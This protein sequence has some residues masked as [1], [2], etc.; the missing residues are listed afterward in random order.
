MLA[1]I[2]GAVDKPDGFRKIH[3]REIPRLGGV[4]V[5]IAF[6]VPIFLLM[7][8]Y[9]RSLISTVLKEHIISVTGLLVGASVAL[10]MGAIDD[11]VDLRARWKLLLQ[12]FAAC[13][14]ITAGY[15]IEILSLP[16]IGTI[17]L[18]WLTWPFTIFWFLGC[19]NAINFLDGMD[20]LAG[21]VSLIVCIT[22]VLVGLLMDNPMSMFLMACL[23]GAILG[24]L[25]HNFHPA[26]IFLG[27]SGSNVLGF[28]IAA[29]AIGSSRK[30]ETA[31]ALLIP[32]IALGL[33]IIDTGLA[34]LRRWSRRLPMSAP[35]RQHIHHLLLSMGLS[36]TK[37]VLI[38]YLASVLLC[39]VAILSIADERELLILLFICVAVV[40]F[41]CVRL[42][43]AVPISELRN[44]FTM[45][46]RQREQANLARI[47]T[48]KALHRM[49]YT[50]E[51]GE[52]WELCAL[53]LTCLKVDEARLMLEDGDVPGWD[54]TEFAWRDAGY[55][56]TVSQSENFWH[57]RF[58][59][60][61]DDD[62]IGFLELSAELPPGR[63]LLPDC[64][65]IVQRLRDA[66][67]MNLLRIRQVQL[68]TA[69]AA[70]AAKAVVTPEIPAK[71]KSLA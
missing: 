46:W 60:D 52:L 47:E 63:A 35:D 10:V 23:S 61:G 7:F 25:L 45:D 19:M 70:A 40:V 71:Q 59:L 24:F 3:D 2:L 20:G 4:G 69:N 67:G 53:P 15:Q 17:R 13:V 57:A 36:Q 21:G 22:M 1:P 37:V 42:L 5:F 49:Q 65:E 68:D 66:L 12:I 56:G 64:V 39:G 43:G 29:L 27:D 50:E 34:I 18:G 31:V 28:L 8:V 9:H 54:G 41:V 44:R 32:V 6:M 51:L 11:M 33:P 30:S 48:E 38:M 55:T 26:R 14:A 16:L 62:P 58:S